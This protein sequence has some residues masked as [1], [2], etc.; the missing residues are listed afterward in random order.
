MVHIN[1]LQE[2]TPISMAQSTRHSKG[3]E[4]WKYQEKRKRIAKEQ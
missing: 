2:E 4:F 1:N 3:Q